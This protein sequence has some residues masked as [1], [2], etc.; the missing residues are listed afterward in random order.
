[1][2][3]TYDFLKKTCNDLKTAGFSPL[4]ILDVGAHMCL[5]A[6]IF[7][8]YWNHANIILVEADK[9]FE[10]LYR[11][12]NYPYY[13]ATVGKD[14]YTSKF[15]KSTNDV[16]KM[17]GSIY[18]ENSKYYNKES[19]IT[20]NHNVVKLDDLI[21]NQNFDLVKID[22]QGAELDVIKGGLN[23]LKNTKVIICEVSL[24]EYNIGGCKKQDLVDY[25]TNV[26]KFD[27]VEIIEKIHDNK[28]IFQENLLFIKQ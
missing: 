9:S 2:S 11:L 18:L 26:L 16:Y 7:K 12:K 4:N 28:T 1:M 14:N 19:I 20:E 5:T 6:D 23:N 13:I 22:V 8:Q 15:Y 21:K 24:T 25:V 17:G 10:Q 27:L 3:Y